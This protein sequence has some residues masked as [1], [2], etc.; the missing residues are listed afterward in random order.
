MLCG[1]MHTVKLFPTQ[2]NSIKHFGKFLCSKQNND[3]VHE[4]FN[5]VI[6]FNNKINRKIFIVF[7]GLGNHLTVQI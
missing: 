2:I 6:I 7:K 4:D 3:A 1:V 5:V